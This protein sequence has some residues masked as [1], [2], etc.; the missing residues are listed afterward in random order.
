MASTT[1]RIGIIGCGRVAR[2]HL[3]RLVAQDGVQIV[4]CADLNPEAASALAAGVP[5]GPARTFA[6]HR[7]LLERAAPQAVSIFTPH[8]AHYR[9]A[10]DALQAGCHVFVEKPLSTNSQEA[11]DI[12]GL[13]RA[14]GRTV[15]V[16]HQYRLRPSLIEARRRLAAGAIGRLRL[17]T[18]VLAQPW[19]AAHVTS[20]DAW[21]YDPKVAGGGILAD[22][23]DH[24]IDALLWT[25]GQVAEEVVAVQSRLETGLDLVTA[26]A[27]RLADGTPVTLAL[28]GDSPAPLFSLTFFGQAG[29]LLA[30]ESTLVY[31]PAAGPPEAVALP[32]PTETIDGN[33]V[34]AVRGTAPLCCPAE[35]A[36]EAVRLLEAI[37]R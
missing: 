21:R 20:A 13:A 37:A 33:F 32:E 2:I 29:R 27:I 34:A 36:L 11:V 19:L 3:P 25:T 18:A 15:G 12:A 28:S 10:M 9:P 7:E 30:T 23:G 16:G 24:L 8:I 22:A 6:D 1:L 26:A 4:G 14:R 5:D 31:E 17:V 35:E